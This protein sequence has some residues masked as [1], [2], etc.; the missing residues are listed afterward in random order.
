MQKVFCV[1]FCCEPKHFWIHWL[2]LCPIQVLVW[3]ALHSHSSHILVLTHPWTLLLPLISFKKTTRPCFRL[4][5]INKFL[6]F[7]WGIVNLQQRVKHLSNLNYDEYYFV[8]RKKNS[9]WM[10]PY[11]TITGFATSLLLISYTL[12]LCI[13]SCLTAKSED[14]A[15]FHHFSVS[16]GLVSVTYSLISLV[17]DSLTI[18]KQWISV[19]E[20]SNW[21]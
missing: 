13:L 19:R 1:S 9:E 2:S 20:A 12:N 3:N 18:W 17:L 6:N 15:E 21:S 8:A 10:S 16:D 5:L 7:R 4:E 14:N 11:I